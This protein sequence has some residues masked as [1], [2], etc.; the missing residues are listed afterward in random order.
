MIVLVEQTRSIVSTYCVWVSRQTQS[1]AI[2]KYMA[3]M[4]TQSAIANTGSIQ[5]DSFC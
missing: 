2:S 4:H 1:A 5:V 3:V